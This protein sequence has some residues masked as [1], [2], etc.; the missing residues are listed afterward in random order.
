MGEFKVPAA[1]SFEKKG[2]RFRVRRAKFGEEHSAVA[3]DAV[4]AGVY[5]YFVA[6]N[7]DKEG[8]ERVVGRYYFQL[9]AKNKR[10]MP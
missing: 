6:T 3:R 5:D 8:D 9:D 1:V 2:L 4:E 10:V 7:V